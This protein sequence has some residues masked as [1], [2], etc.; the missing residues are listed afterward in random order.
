MGRHIADLSSVS[1]IRQIGA[2]CDIRASSNSNPV[3]SAD[4][5][6]KSAQQRHEMLVVGSHELIPLDGVPWYFLIETLLDPNLA[7]KCAKS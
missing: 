3:H 4:Q 1:Q 7:V 5:R 2:E 6:L